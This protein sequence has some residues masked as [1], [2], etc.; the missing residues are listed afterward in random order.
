MRRLLPVA[1][2]LAALVA[3][4]AAWDWDERR[5][6]QGTRLVSV[7]KVIKTIDS[8]RLMAR[9]EAVSI[10]NSRWLYVEHGYVKFAAGAR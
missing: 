6:P 9:S 1:I 8:G 10:G 3:V 4:L 2:G 5:A 7:G